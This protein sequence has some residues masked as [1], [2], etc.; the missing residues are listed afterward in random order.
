[1]L[2]C[3]S[4][5]SLGH[6]IVLNDVLFKLQPGVNL[7][8]HQPHIVLNMGSNVCDHKG[9]LIEPLLDLFLLGFE[10]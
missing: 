5:T 9:L 1:M 6:A 7:S 4:E 2:S 8:G 3:K 10:G